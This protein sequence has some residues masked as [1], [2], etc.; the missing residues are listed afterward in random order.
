MGR[1]IVRRRGCSRGGRVMLGAGEGCVMGGE[2]WHLPTCGFVRERYNKKKGAI[3]F[4]P[5]VNRD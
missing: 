3:G 1:G 2:G 5:G 4:M